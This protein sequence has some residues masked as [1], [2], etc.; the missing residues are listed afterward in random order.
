MCLK[1]A[2]GGGRGEEIVWMEIRDPLSS[3]NGAV[4]RQPQRASV[5]D[6]SAKGS[7]WAQ[8]GPRT[9]PSHR[10][11]PPTQTI[12]TANFGVTTE[13]Q[14]S[15]PSGIQSCNSEYH[16]N[17]AKKLPRA[18]HSA[19]LH[20]ANNT[21]VAVVMVTRNLEKLLVFYF[22]HSSGKWR[23]AYIMKLLSNICSQRPYSSMHC[24]NSI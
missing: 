23:A 22:K 2:E 1:Y 11:A 3:E 19:K 9:C 24:D 14:I 16:F 4:A 18:T 8:S 10:E 6:G 7:S 15:I 21:K 13:F 17:K 20:W 12:H 5:N